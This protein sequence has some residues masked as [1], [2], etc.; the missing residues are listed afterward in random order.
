MSLFPRLPLTAKRY[1]PGMSDPTGSPSPVSPMPPMGSQ[2]GNVTPMMSPP[3]QGAPQNAFLSPRSS[4]E[5]SYQGLHLSPQDFKA[6]GPEVAT[7]LEWEDAERGRGWTQGNLHQGVGYLQDKQAAPEVEVDPYPDDYWANLKTKHEG[8][9]RSWADRQT[10]RAQQQAVAGGWRKLGM[11]DPIKNEIE[12]EMLRNIQTGR[13]EMD[14]A[15]ADSMR[16][17]DYKNAELAL[18]RY[19]MEGQLN[20]GRDAQSAQMLANAQWQPHNFTGAYGFLDSHGGA[21]IQGLLSGMQ[22]GPPPHMLKN[23]RSGEFLVWQGRTYQRKGDQFIPSTGA[24]PG[25]GG[26]GD[27]RLPHSVDWTSVPGMEHLAIPRGSPDDEWNTAPRGG[28]P[29]LIRS[30]PNPYLNQGGRR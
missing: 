12:N 15:Q 28:N 2:G 24:N 30:T 11:W 18:Q 7:W 5:S 16:Q 23:V 6:M 10:R 3:K 27:A 17:T 21:G 25:D 22:Q 19:S 9:A 20:A 8:Q 29:D 14:I 4:R 13:R 26:W 1:T